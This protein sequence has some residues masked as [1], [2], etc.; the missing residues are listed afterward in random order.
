VCVCA[1][2]CVG[3]ACGSRARGVD[4]ID[5]GSDGCRSLSRVVLNIIFFVFLTFLIKFV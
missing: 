5:G 4:L 3:G 2:A 1:R